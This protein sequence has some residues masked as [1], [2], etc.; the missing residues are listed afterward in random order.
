M[1]P[2]GQ[3]LRARREVLGLTEREAAKALNIDTRL[4]KKY[5]DSKGSSIPVIGY[6]TLMLACVKLGVNL[7]TLM[8]HSHEKVLRAEVLSAPPPTPIE[9]P[10]KGEIL[11]ITKNKAKAGTLE[12]YMQECN[13]TEL[14]LSRILPNGNQLPKGIA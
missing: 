8:A 9:V 13:Q 5:E 12:I 4:Y 3:A 6:R 14:V 11:F 7:N 2:F 10:E 1:K